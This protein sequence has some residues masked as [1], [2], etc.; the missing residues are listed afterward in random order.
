MNE[1]GGLFTESDYRRVLRDYDIITS[2]CLQYDFTYYEGYADAHNIHDLIVTG[3]VIREK[4]P[5]YYPDFERMVHEKHAYFGNI[6]VTSKKLFDEYA[7]WLFTIFFEV[8]KRIDVSSYD[9]YHKRVYGFIS[10]FLLLVWV[11][12]RKLRVYEC[13]VGMSEEKY[14]TREMKRHLAEYFA[15][16]EIAEAKSYFMNC[17]KERPDVLLEASDITGELKLS[18]QV[19]STCEN[20][21]AQGLPGVLD[22][23]RDF[24]TLMRWFR[25]LN[26]IAMHVKN[27]EMTKEDQ[28]FL[29]EEHVSPVAAQIAVMLLGLEP[30]AEKRVITEIMETIV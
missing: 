13:M 5:E 7:S 8:E 30:D 18:M 14:E 1:Q 22:T 19:I 3:E 27:H 17:I 24:S 4:F 6:C 12:H 2:K 16:G 21:Q 25:R 15:K 29:M 20:E 26:Q 23:R 10:E 28:A 9:A 11:T